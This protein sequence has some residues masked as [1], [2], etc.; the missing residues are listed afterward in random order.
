MDRSKIQTI[1]SWLGTGSINIFGLIFAGKDTQ[2][3]RLAKL[4]DAPV[5]SSGQIIREG[6]LSQ[7]ATAIVDKGG[8]APIAD[9]LTII[10][11]YLRLN[12]FVGKPIILSSVGRWDGEQETVLKAAKEAGH[13]TKAVI[14]LNISE[15]EARKRWQADEAKQ[16]RGQRAD[17]SPEA[18][19]RRLQEYRSKTLPVI[20]YYRDHGLLIEVDGMGDRDL[21]ANQILDGLYKRAAGSNPA[22]ALP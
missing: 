11:P 9:F 14:Y 19:E 1:K 15:D 16:N 10:P 20:E 17:D 4:F 2:A 7:Q 13:Q 21:I 6:A 18:F 12:K 5:I 22:S 3:E 8:L